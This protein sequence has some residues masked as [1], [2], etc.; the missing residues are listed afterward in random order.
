[1]FSEESA[2]ESRI[3]ATLNDEKI[4]AEFGHSWTRA[5]VQRVLT[6]EKYAGHN[7][8]NH[9]SFKLKRARVRNPAEM[10]IRANNVF[11]AIIDAATFA[12]TQAIIEARAKRL[13]D[14]EML[15]L[16]SALL[17]DRGTLSAIVIDE[18]AGL[19]S[20]N[21]YRARFGSLFRA[22]RLVGFSSFGRDD[23]YIEINRALRKLHP[24]IVARVVEGIRALKGATVDDQ[25]EGL[26][27]VNEEFSVSIII[28]RCTRTGGGLLRWKL[29]LGGPRT[30]I[31]VAVRMQD[32]NEQVLD[33]YLFPRLD[34][35]AVRLRLG[36]ENGVFL[37]AYRSGSLDRLYR[38]TARTDVRRVA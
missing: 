14:E 29:R 26:L 34:F 19:P 7:V 30:D 20:S 16:L 22:Y 13:T 10:W 27:Q 15:D 11:P 28:C 8:Y 37:D 1:M 25:G 24:G 17:R 4:R 2:G 32:G 33:Y 18:A 36:E 3:A 38:L 23:Q 12:A 9:V 6:S 31:T 5:S 21:I 35:G